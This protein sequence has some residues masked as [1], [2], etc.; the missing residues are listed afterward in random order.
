[1]FQ[2]LRHTAARFV[3]MKTPVGLRTPDVSSLRVSAPFL[4][5]FGMATQHRTMGSF[6]SVRSTCSRT[7]SGATTW[8]SG[9]L[10]NTPPI[11]TMVW[12]TTFEELTTDPLGAIWMRPRD[13]RDITQGTAFDPR[14]PPERIYRRQPEREALVVE[15]LMK[16]RLFEK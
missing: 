9:L 13:Y 8:R 12:L 7:K 5:L 11:L 14:R 3:G 1:M 15:K 4:E 6:R 16:L 2:P 10:Q